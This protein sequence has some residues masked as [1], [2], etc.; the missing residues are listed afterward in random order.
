MTDS[1]SAAGR[2]QTPPPIHATDSGAEIA[3]KM[4][5][6][7]IPVSLYALSPEATAD[8]LRELP[9]DR[10]RE[11][12]RDFADRVIGR[13][14][15]SQERVLEEVEEQSIAR[16]LRLDFAAQRALTIEAVGR[17]LRLGMIEQYVADEIWAAVRVALDERAAAGEGAGATPSHAAPDFDTLKAF[18]QDKYKHDRLY[19]R[20]EEYGDTVVRSRLED[21]ERNG[22]DLISHHESKTGETVYFRFDGARLVECGQPPRRHAAHR[23]EGTSP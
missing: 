2:P 17:H 1:A 3:E 23:Q 18:L 13:A 6:F 15:V 10:E 8:A 21:L 19:G 20:G 12:F 7:G 11:R 14:Y 4:N 16:G 9:N 5:P 22:H